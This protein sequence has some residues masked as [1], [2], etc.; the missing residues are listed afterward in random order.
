MFYVRV[1]DDRGSEIRAFYSKKSADRFAGIVNHE[2]DDAGVVGSAQRCDGRTARLLMEHA[3]RRA[4]SRASV[5]YTVGDIPSMTMDELY[6]VYAEYV[7]DL[8][9]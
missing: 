6:D 2:I 1:N 4:A 7:L 3:L 5:S 9:C 8:D